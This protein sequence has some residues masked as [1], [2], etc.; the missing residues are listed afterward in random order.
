PKSH[1]LDAAC[2]GRLGGVRDWKLPTLIVTCRGR[3]Q[4]QRTKPDRHGFPRLRLPSAKDVHGFRT[5][6]MVRAD[7]PKGRHAGTHVGRVAVRKSGSFAVK[8]MDGVISS[9]WK[10]CRLLRKG[11]G[12]SWGTEPYMETDKS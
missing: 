4:Y 3:G 2:V 11:N 8:T 12:Y 7:I 10:H 5:G 9:S 1:A 6:D